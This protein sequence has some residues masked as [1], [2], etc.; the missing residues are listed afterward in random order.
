MKQLLI[1]P[2]LALT[3][4]ACGS[5]ST[6]SGTAPIS[7]AGTWSGPYRAQD[8]ADAFRFVFTQTGSTINGEAYVG[9]AGAAPS[10]FHD[11]GAIYG[12][13]NGSNL[14]FII[15]DKYVL[16]GTVGNN[17]NSYVGTVVY[18]PGTPSVDSGTFSVTR[19]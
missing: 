16:N 10:T 15:S 17:G 14:N 13:L 4:A 2:A 9:A 1:L 11:I 18:L 5:T 3:L 12:T 19:Q 7:I 8:E 6:P